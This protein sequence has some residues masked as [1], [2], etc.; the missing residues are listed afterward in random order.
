MQCG[1]PGPIP[2]PKGRNADQLIKELRWHLADV[3]AR[4]GQALLDEPHRLNGREYRKEMK[5]A[6]EL[7]AEIER[8]LAWRKIQPKHV[9]LATV[10][11]RREAPRLEQKTIIDC[12][13]I[14]AYNAEEWLLE[15][16]LE[17]YPRSS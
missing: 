8:M 6:R 7:E 12:V 14:A 1:K 10:D 9:P 15:R 11:Q 2:N 13:K 4:L 5:Q 16:L 3:R 17:H